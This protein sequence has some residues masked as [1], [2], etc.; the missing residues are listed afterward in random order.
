MV[1][2]EEPWSYGEGTI[3]F[4]TCNKIVYQ[5]AKK[6]GFN[7]FAE[8]TY[9]DSKKTNYQIMAPRKKGYEFI[10]RMKNE[11][12]N[13]KSGHKKTCVKCAKVFVA[14]SNNQKACFLC[15]SDLKKETDRRRQE[16]YRKKSIDHKNVTL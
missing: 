3:A 10:K 16:R 9:P 5:E 2:L 12:N 7:V 13:N 8:Y 14:N 11:I 1:F 15:R 4:R 6:A